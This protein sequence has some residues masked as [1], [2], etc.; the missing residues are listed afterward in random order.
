[1]KDGILASI[2]TQLGIDTAVD[3]F[4]QELI[5]HINSNLLSLTQLGIGPKNGFVISG[6]AETWNQFLGE[7]TDLEAVKSLLYFKVKLNFD[8]PSNSF[9]MQAIEKTIEELTW[10]LLLQANQV[11]EV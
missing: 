2:K 7:R 11:M 10:R 5:I 9:L 6:N 3:H 4:D 8:P 1:M